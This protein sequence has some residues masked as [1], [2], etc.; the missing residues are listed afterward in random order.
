MKTV[1][2]AEAWNYFDDTSGIRK[3]SNS[4][5]RG[6]PGHRVSSYLELAQKVAELQFRNPEHV[7]LFRGQAV[8]YKNQKRNT[9]LKP[10]LFRHRRQDNFRPPSM[11]VLAERFAKLRTAEE[12]LTRLFDTH[13]LE[14][15]K[16]LQRHRILRWAIA[17]HYEL[18]L[19]PLLD[20]TQSIR[21]AA[22][23]ASDG[24]QG[25]V[26]FYVL[27]APNI[28]GAVT[29]SAEAELQIVRLAGICPPMAVRPHIQEGYLLGEYP[30]LPDADQKGLY[31]SYEIDFGRR[32][33][34]KFRFD[35]ETFW[36][37]P[38]FQQIPHQAL[39]PDEQDELFHLIEPLKDPRQQES[40]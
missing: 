29:A 1:G 9:T 7:L 10:S 6:A 26:F 18:C 37:D 40:A 11:N 25:E 27:A 8:E 33:I 14:G 13:N 24:V 19:T 31:S 17:Q 15:K 16:R 21:V 3:V 23:F 5:V 32:L 22:S 39:Y 2:K 28:S 20:V 38:N 4:T 30:D 34:A 12:R 35:V 36:R